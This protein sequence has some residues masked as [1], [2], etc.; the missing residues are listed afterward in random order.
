EHGHWSRVIADVFFDHFLAC[1]FEEWGREPLET[2]VARVHATL[3]QHLD[4]LPERLR[5]VYP[6]MR[7][8]GWLLGYR[9]REGIELALRGL[10]RRIARHPP[11]YEAMHLLDDAR[12]ELERRFRAFF[13]DVMSF[14]KW[15]GVR[16]SR[17][18]LGGTVECGRLVRTLGQAEHRCLDGSGS[19][20]RASAPHL[21]SRTADGAPLP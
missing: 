15:S 9:E 19:R 7:R 11:L 17:P 14:A 5:A 2:F 4:L 3:D 8:E 18:H 13:P 16:T 1:G 12:G 20:T 10:S 6:F 21:F